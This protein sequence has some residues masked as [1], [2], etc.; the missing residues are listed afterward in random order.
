MA[1][2]YSSTK[3]ME[4]ILKQI[5]KKGK[6]LYAEL[7]QQQQ[8]I[9]NNPLIGKELKGDLNDFRSHDFNF[10]QVAIRI[11]Y[12]YH[13]DDNHVTFVYCGTRENFYKEAKRYLY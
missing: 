5:E 9:I 13:E 10:Q 6:K 1:L 11:I 8:E 4:K 2:T 12:A 7:N 3:K